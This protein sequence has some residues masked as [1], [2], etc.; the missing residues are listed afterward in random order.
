MRAVGQNKICVVSIDV[1]EDIGNTGKNRFRGVENLDRVLK[2]FQMFEIKATLFVTGEVLEAY[3]YLI[4]RWSKIH[5]IACHGYYHTPLYVLS[6]SERE[7][8]LDDFCRLYERIVS[9]KPKGFRAVRHTIDSDQLKLLEK[10]GL[11]YDSSVMPNYPFV[12]KYVGYKG[13]A[14]T[15]PYFPD[16]DDYKRRGDMKVLEIP[17]TP[18]IFGI[19]LSGTW[20]RVFGP[21]FYEFVLKLKKPPFISLTMH[22]WDCIKWEGKYSRNSGEEFIKALEN[23]L[24]LLQDEYQFINAEEISKSKVEWEGQNNYN[25]N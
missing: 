1:E 2:I 25:G 14:P 24:G 17:V 4:E 15:E 8:Q 23:I 19:P 6:L 12:R 22:S 11:S 21:K 7:K 3:P 9:D 5:E 18:L 10:F 13:K 16:Y 20:I